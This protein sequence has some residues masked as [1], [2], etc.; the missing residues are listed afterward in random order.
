MTDRKKLYQLSR[1]NVLAGLGGIGLASAGAGL[2]TT[3]YFND[4]ESFDGNVMTA[5]T[6]DLLVGY[7]SYWDQGMAGSGQVVGTNDGSGTVSGTLTDVKPGDS[8]LLAFCPRIDG[9][10]AYLWLCGELTSNDENGQNEPEMD[11]DTTTGVGEGEL[12]QNI[13]ITAS[14]CQLDGDIGDN[15]GFE[16]SDVESSTEVWTGSF[17]EF[18]SAIRNGVPL[19]GEGTTAAEG[20][21]PTPGDQACYAGTESGEAANPCLCIDWSVPSDVGNEI[22]SDTLTF[23]L[24]FHAQQCRHNDGTTNPCAGE[25]EPCSLPTGQPES[26]LV[27]VNSVDA[28]SFPDVSAFLRVDTAAGNAGDLTAA[29]F[30]VCE[31]GLAQD[32]SVSFTSESAADIVFVFDDTGSM[33][34]EIQGAKNAI[35]NFVNSLV[36]TAGIDTRFA[37]VSYKD[38]V[39]LDQDFTSTQTEIEAAIDGLSASGGGDGRE[40]NFDAIGVATRDIG[41]DSPSGAMLSPYRSGAQK[42]IIDITDAPAQVD[43]S[44]AYNNDESRTDYVMSDVEALLDGFTYIAVSDDLSTSGYSDSGYA[45]GDKQ[46]LANN[47]GGTWFE[48]PTGNSDEFSTLLEEE[49]SGLLTTAYTLTYTSCDDD[50]D[51]VERPILI[52]VTDPEEGKLYKTTSITVP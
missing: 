13:E 31:N 9:N 14:Y 16:R 52:E 12:A 25:C 6:L 1:R 42:V 2:G 21:F 34:D 5:G 38:T 19:D 27:Q 22:Q 23:D 40:D 3:A 39:Q 10:P 43:D 49:V 17:A 51:P 28:S 8:G 11:A 15:G 48:L 26:A 36:T 29:N 46:I 44:T 20:G 45:D 50:S 7:Y 24:E 4:T 32:E 35:S 30:E 41:A 47:V 18:L 33:G 37:L